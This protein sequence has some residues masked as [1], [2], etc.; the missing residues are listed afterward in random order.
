MT[1]WE[2]P[3]LLTNA[4]KSLIKADKFYQNWEAAFIDDS[5]MKPGK[6]VVQDMVPHLVDKFKFYNTE[7]TIEE[8]IRTG[9]NLG[10]KINQVIEESDAD[11]AIF[12]SDDDALEERCL[13][14]ISQFFQSS[15]ELC[16]YSQVHVWNPLLENI[17]EVNN[18]HSYLK[19]INSHFVLVDDSPLSSIVP[20]AEITL[21]GSQIAWRIFQKRKWVAEDRVVSLDI[22][23][24]KCFES[25]PYS[26]FV[27]QY[28][29]VF[30][31]NLGKQLDQ[32]G[33]GIKD[34]WMNK[35]L[36]APKLML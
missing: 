33:C 36:D 3:V 6:P 28:K 1:Y 35:T 32:H 22:D 20:S 18:P 30:Q 4:L 14:R 2:R 16:C 29:S 24:Y 11:V 17:E 26:G 19:R 21:D 5:S 8:K 23:L 7:T 27:A 34:V 10:K 9:G 25:I 12:L 15:E 13:M 31:N